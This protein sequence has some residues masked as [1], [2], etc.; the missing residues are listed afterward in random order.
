MTSEQEQ[1]DNV[2]LV[3]GSNRPNLFVPYQGVEKIV[4]S[5]IETPK[6]PEGTSPPS[7]PPRGNAQVPLGLKTARGQGK[8]NGKSR[9]LSAEQCSKLKQAAT[10]Y[11]A[12]S[13]RLYGGKFIPSARDVEAL[14]RHFTPLEVL[15]AQVQ[16][17]WFGEAPKKSMAHF[18]AEGA[19]TTI[20]DARLRGVSRVLPD[21]YSN[22]LSSELRELLPDWNR[23]IETWL[24]AFPNTPREE[25]L[26][27]LPEERIV[28]IKNSQLQPPKTATPAGQVDR[29]TKPWCDRLNNFVAGECQSLGDID[30]W[31][32]ANPTDNGDTATREDFYVRQ[33]VTMIV[34]DQKPTLNAAYR[35]WDEQNATTTPW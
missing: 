2:P 14:L 7:V 22:S 25:L 10:L 21:V 17:F 28:K 3:D 1:R 11:S 15:F 35:Q 9:A 30:T 4:D 20:E 31:L 34:R 29:A 12:F 5:E 24:G 33:A 23:L 18:F 16:K 26:I 6:S 32:K 8:P 19:K 27:K 13:D